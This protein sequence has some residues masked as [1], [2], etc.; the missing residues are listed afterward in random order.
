MWRRLLAGVLLFGCSEEPTRELASSGCFASLQPSRLSFGVV[1]HGRSVSRA[2]QISNEGESACVIES[3]RAR[4]ESAEL[5]I[6]RPMLPAHLA[7]G[8][9]VVVRVELRLSSPSY[10]DTIDVMM[11]SGERLAIRITGV[12]AGSRPLVVPS[13]VAFQ[14]LLACT[15]RREVDVYNPDTHPA[16]VSA[17]IAGSSQAFR[18][19]NRLPAS[20]D[21]GERASLTV[22]FAPEVEGEHEA[23][24]E[25]RW[26]MA[27]GE[28]GSTAVD[29]RGVAVRGVRRSELHSGP[30]RPTSDFLFVIDDSPS[31]VEEQQVL[32]ANL[33]AL[34]Q[35]LGAQGYDARVGVTTTD[36]SSSGPAG[37]ILPRDGAR[38]LTETSPWEAW[39]ELIRVGTAGST[40]TRGLEA[41]A[42]AIEDPSGH[43]AGFLRPGTPL[44]VVIISGGDDASPF[45]VDHY[46]AALQRAVDDGTISAVVG[47]PGGC[48]GPGGVA[49]EGTRYLAAAALSGGIVSPICNSDWERAFEDL[50][51][52]TTPAIRFPLEQTPRPGTIDL[53][54]DGVPVPA[55]SPGGTEQWWWEPET[56]TMR[57]APWVE[58]P[59]DSEIVISYEPGC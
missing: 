53:T 31:M 37:R 9:A 54:I 25:V 15:E 29:L 44:R 5:R 28:A 48:Q 2:I 3:I 50:S 8:D 56:N 36:T 49:S 22:T 39:L 26:T 11:E 38:F 32:E 46:V 24:L 1:E 33:A 20:L 14:A 40:V 47:P 51:G 42:L 19:N 18:L 16:A 35:F 12:T 43:N 4:K 21:P 57:L 59:F 41:M 23:V 27:S 13:E 6:N 30:S 58:L 52:T 10:D 55:V 17:A 34:H 7:P 45:A